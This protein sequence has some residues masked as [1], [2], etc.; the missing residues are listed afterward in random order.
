MDVPENLS[1]PLPPTLPLL[2]P[3]SLPKRPTPAIPPQPSAV[4]C[5]KPFPPLL[6][7][8]GLLGGW[9]LQPPFTSE[10]MQ[11][12]VLTAGEA[13]PVLRIQRD[14]EWTLVRTMC[15]DGRE[16][17]T[18]AAEEEGADGLEVSF[19]LPPS[20]EPRV[21]QITCSVFEGA[22]S[23]YTLLLLLKS[24][25]PPSQ[26]DS[27]WS[28]AGLFSAAGGVLLVLFCLGAVIW[29]RICQKKRRGHTLLASV[30]AF[31]ETYL[32]L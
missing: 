20:A 25:P 24:E 16:N 29:Q 4:P 27:G 14:S 8:I 6:V 15:W 17:A 30:D 5:V 10:H 1:L 28:L 32:Q 7:S 21:C 19:T 31:S 11:Y 13:P 2:S 18:L 9:M 22:T 23:T 12:S 26:I 3:P